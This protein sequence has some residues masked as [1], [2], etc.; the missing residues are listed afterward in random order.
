MFRSFRNLKLAYKLLIPLS[1]LMLT[2]AAILWI[3]Q[4]GIGELR[5]AT[6]HII[7]VSAAR[8]AAGLTMETNFND[9]AIQEKLI[10]IETDEAKSKAYRDRFNQ[11]MDLATAAIDKLIGLAD[12]PERLALNNKIKG[13]LLAFRRLAETSIALS[14]HHDK[15]AALRL[16]MSDI[17]V[18]RRAFVNENEVVTAR[19][20][21]EM[22][23]A[24]I[25]SKDLGEKVLLQLYVLAGVGLAFSVGLLATIILVL[26]LRPLSAV[27]GSMQR[28]AAGDTTVE[29]QG[30]ERRDEIGTLAQS[31][32]V[33]K[34]NGLKAI[35]LEA[36]ITADRAAAEL[37]RARLEAER[38]QEAAE[39]QLAITAL[40]RGLEALAMGNL[41]YQI[42]EDVAPKTRQL[43]D[44]F[45][46][47]AASLRETITTI[48]GAIQG[49]T[50][51][52][53]EISQAA[54]DLSRRTEQQAASLEQTAAALD[55]IT[56]TVR[57][58]AEGATHV[59]AVVSTAKT[60]AEH[61]SGVVQEA[62]VAMNEITKSS[63]EVGQIIG[64]MD[65]IAFQTNLLALNAGVEAA[66]AGDAG[67][68]FAVVASEVRALAQRSAQAAKEI[69]QLIATSSQQVGHGVKLVNETGDS[70]QRI[71]GHVAEAYKAVTEI[72]ASA[73]EQAAGLHEVNVAVNQM[74]QV[75]QQNA[76]MVEQN[77]AASHSLTQETVELVRLT[78]RFQIG[79][80]PGGPMP[81]TNVKPL[82]RPAKP[83]PRATKVTAL[84][85]VSRG[86]SAVIDANSVPNLAEEGWSEF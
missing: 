22:E 52:T 32:Q 42:T 72:A 71:V 16:S 62:V 18:A 49:M 21:V 39:D 78:E 27:T 63:Q 4:S 33:F 43:K 67:R 26:V 31:L 80:A 75:T 81:G 17:I 1:L 85:V 61:S 5:A 48:A 11:R 47:T 9:A 12:T 76:A 59:Q 15:E 23:R 34:D 64:V 37:E 45:N 70:L 30:A 40:A 86:G 66:R 84:K 65:E 58:T 41:T 55:Q 6:D 73:K 10:T 74:D 53:G 56:A 13:D 44:D 51:G 77:T 79:A 35:A 83:M 19:Q 36:E 14:F 7:N 82:H 2:I 29:V 3:A 57:K 54:D 50:N 20:T 24:K 8:R 68:G 46:V 25:Q 69:K 38:A 60:D 28:L